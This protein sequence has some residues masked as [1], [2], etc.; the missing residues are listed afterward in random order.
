VWWGYRPVIP[1]LRRRK[2]EDYEFEASLGFYENLSQKT[3]TTKKVIE[4][5]NHKEIFKYLKYILSKICWL[6]PVIQ[7]CGML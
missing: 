6:T 2:E 5:R 3:A 7:L 4:T 1:A